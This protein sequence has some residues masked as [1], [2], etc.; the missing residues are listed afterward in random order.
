MAT[1]LSRK[2]EKERESTSNME[3]SV[4]NL[5]L[6]MTSH[7]ICYVVLTRSKLLRSVK[8]LDKNLK[9]QRLLESTLEVTTILYTE[10]I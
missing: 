5:T 4:F 6:D 7:Y 1:V 8:E 2:G 3:A 9:R 10:Y